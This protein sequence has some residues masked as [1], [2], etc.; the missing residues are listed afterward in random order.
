MLELKLLKKVV[1]HH[2]G[3]MRY[4]VASWDESWFKDGEGFHSRVLDRWKGDP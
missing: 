3:K 4:V 2:V 1:F